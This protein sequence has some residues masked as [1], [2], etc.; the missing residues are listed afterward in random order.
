MSI[1]A[2]QMAA[3]SGMYENAGALQ[4]QEIEQRYKLGKAQIAGSYKIAQLESKDKR[5]GIEE[6]REY[7]RGTLEQARQEME[8]IGI[9]EMEIK[10]FVADKNYEIAQ[11]ELAY[12][13][14]ALEEERRQ[15]EKTYG[16]TEAG[17]T[18][19]FG[20]QKTLEARMREAE[21]ARLLGGLTGT[22]GGQDTLARQELLG[23]QAEQARRY[24]LDVAK[25]GSDLANQ[26][27]RYFQARRFRAMEAPRLL[28][29]DTSG[30]QFGG[31]PVPQMQTMGALLSGRDP[32]AAYGGPSG[33]A[34]PGAPQDERSK[35]IAQIAKA[36]PPSP[37]D[38]LDDGDAATLRLMESVYKRGGQGIPG[39]ELERMGTAQRGFLA[40]AGSLLGFDPNDLEQQYK[41]YRPAQGAANLA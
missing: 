10:R 14:E 27:D 3:L 8:R 12:K 1:S 29:Q 32:A 26:P 6:T 16:L 4:L 9:P 5:A 7:H 28:G 20:G 39:G 23:T 24:G 30:G 15:Y 37:Y 11:G 33:A 34:P 31:Q 40:S 17:V 18:G 21:E 35:Q 19:M 36:S 41:A 2:A 25:Y 38:G 13:R 22:Y